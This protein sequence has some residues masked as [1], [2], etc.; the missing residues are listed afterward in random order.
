MNVQQN[1]NSRLA[2]P[3]PEHAVMK[4]S[5]QTASRETTEINQKCQ[6][7][8]PIS[9]NQNTTTD[10][11]NLHRPS[12]VKVNS[13]ESSVNNVNAPSKLDTTSTVCSNN[14][15]DTGMITIVTIKNN[16]NNLDNLSKLI[17]DGNSLV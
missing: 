2:V 11:P 8:Q 4:S 9:I 6:Q 14:E 5:G 12:Q 13:C 10:V 15:Q 1:S 7:Q 17:N 16:S 3:S